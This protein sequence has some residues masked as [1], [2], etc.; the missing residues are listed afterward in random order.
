MQGGKIKK[1]LEGKKG[2]GERREAGGKNQRAETREGWPLLTVESEC[3]DSKSSN[4]RG[5]SLVGSFLNL[6][7]R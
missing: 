3:G 1:E 4:E 2:I 7:C 6:S 5:H